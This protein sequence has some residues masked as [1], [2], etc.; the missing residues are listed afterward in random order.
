MKRSKTLADKAEAV[1][2][3]AAGL[4]TSRIAVEAADATKTLAVAASVALEKV[5]AVAGRV[6]HMI[7]VA[8]AKAVS[9]FPNLQQDMRDLHNSQ[10]AQTSTIIDVVTKLIEAHTGKEEAHLATLGESVLGVREDVGKIEKHMT[11]Q[12]GRMAKAETHIIRQNLIIFGISAPIGLL[13]IGYFAPHIVEMSVKTGGWGA[14]TVAVV[15]VT[16]VL[17]IL[18]AVAVKLFRQPKAKP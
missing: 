10:S 17:T 5:D 14:I 9:E 13:I 18:L 11:T 12:N 3:A 4:A 2:A 1:I 7:E 6:L 8:A 16:L 15:A